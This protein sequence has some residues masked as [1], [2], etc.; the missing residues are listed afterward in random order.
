M[1][2]GRAIIGSMTLKVDGYVPTTILTLNENNYR[3][4]DE[5]IQRL[6]HLYAREEIPTDVPDDDRRNIII[7]KL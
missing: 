4:P 5:H 7:G 2:D 3:V 6:E 1:E